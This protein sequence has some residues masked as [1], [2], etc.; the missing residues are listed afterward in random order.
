MERK[1]KTQQQFMAKSAKHKRVL[2]D[3]DSDDF[4]EPVKKGFHGTGL[5][6][7]AMGLG[8]DSDEDILIGLMGSKQ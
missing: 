2:E 3:S 8:D 7:E 1:S 4:D 6:F 5:K